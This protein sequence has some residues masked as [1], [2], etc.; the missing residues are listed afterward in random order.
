MNNR[1]GFFR[2]S[3]ILS[4]VM[5]VVVI[6]AVTQL[7]QKE[8]QNYKHYSFIHEVMNKYTPV[9]N[10]G[11]DGTCWAYAMLAAIETEH[12]MRGDSVNLSPYYAVRSSLEEQMMRYYLS[13]GKTGVYE[14]GTG[15]TLLNTMAR[16][17]MV[18]YDAY[19]PT[20]NPQTAVVI[21]K[22]KAAAAAAINAKVGLKRYRAIIT[23]LLDE[24]FGVKPKQVYMLGAQYTPLE[25]AR[26][27]CTYNEYASYTSF[28]HHA[29]N[30]RFVLEVADNWELDETYNLPLDTLV[31]RVVN[32]VQQGRGVCWEGDISEPG[33]SFRRGIAVLPSKQ[34]VD[35]QARQ[36]EYENF[37][38][39]DDHCMAIV[40]LARDD[41]GQRY[42]VMKNSWGTDN[43]YGGLMYMSEDYLRMKT[44]AVFMPCGNQP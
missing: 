22:I 21:K 12:L 34:Q 5:S 36:E 9:K 44:I 30:S 28:T 1:C 20:V 6:T 16:K 23:E 35:Q 29:M 19:N 40:G 3:L 14:R 26:S 27:V 41:S 32:A 8:P 11:N 24:S 10:Q 39:T 37:K 18:A 17:G 25:F 38:T 2:T 15:H 33:F 7:R 4:V 43:P 42:F 13:M 31:Q